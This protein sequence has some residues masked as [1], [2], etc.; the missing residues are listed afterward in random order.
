[1]PHG[2]PP[3]L[4][5]AESYIIVT[6]ESVAPRLFGDGGQAYGGPRLARRGVI[7]CGQQQNLCTASRSLTYRA[8]VA[9]HAHFATNFNEIN[10]ILA[11]WAFL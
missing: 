4:S 9:G 11:S 3:G 8:I 10:W 6:P 7:N 5:L 1:M 2:V